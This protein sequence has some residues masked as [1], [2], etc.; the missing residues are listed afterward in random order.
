MDYDN[1]K[2]AYTWSIPLT[3]YVFD[4]KYAK[5]ENSIGCIF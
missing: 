5:I 4:P 1:S 2:L 3:S